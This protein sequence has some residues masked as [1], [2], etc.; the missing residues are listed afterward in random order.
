MIIY[1]KLQSADGD[2]KYSEKSNRYYKKLGLNAIV[3]NI[4]ERKQ[5]GNIRPLLLRYQPDILV[6][7][8]T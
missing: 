4:P 6:I 3:R 2:R 5:T 1:I 8:R 7:T